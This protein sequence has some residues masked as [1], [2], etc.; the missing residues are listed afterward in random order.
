MVFSSPSFAGCKVPSFEKFTNAKWT[1]DKPYYFEDSGLGFSF[2]FD[3]PKATGNLYVYD[4]GISRDLEKDWKQQ[5][6]QS[7][8]DIYYHYEK[9]VPD[10]KLSNPRLVPDKLVSHLKLINVAA[11]IVVSKKPVEQLTIVSMGMANG[12]FHKFRYTQTMVSSEKTDVILDGLLGFL[13]LP[14]P[15]I[16]L[17]SLPITCNNSNTH[18]PP[19]VVHRVS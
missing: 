2:Q 18:P 17:F 6:K 16:V 7:I 8:S 19:V 15:S 9:E 1:V 5:F 12:C 14:I 4:L 10:A 3:S 11:F 13:G